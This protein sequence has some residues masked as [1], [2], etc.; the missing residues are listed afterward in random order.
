M[1]DEGPLWPHLQMLSI[2]N[3]LDNIS[4][5]QLRIAKLSMPRAVK[6]VEGVSH[7]VGVTSNFPSNRY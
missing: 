5:T 3:R 2:V 6:T 1:I 7:R 4:Y